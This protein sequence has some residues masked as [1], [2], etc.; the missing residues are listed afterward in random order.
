MA[1]PSLR[2]K[3]APTRKAL[4]KPV[5]TREISCNTLIFFRSGLARDSL[6]RCSPSATA[7]QRTRSF[8]I[9]GPASGGR[10]RPR[11]AGDAESLPILTTAGHAV[12][13]VR[14]RP[15][16]ASTALT[17]PTPTRRRYKGHRE[18]Y[19]LATIE[20]NT[21]GIV[22]EDDLPGSEALAAWLDYLQGGS[23]CELRGVFRRNHQGV[24]TLAQSSTALTVRDL[25]TMQ[26]SHHKA[27]CT[28]LKTEDS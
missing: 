19:R 14:E 7:A 25:H 16:T 21:L 8:S 27:P 26:F 24:V 9:N 13:P 4:N 5:A 20:R 3:F 22:R 11:G 6:F 18:N 15:C 23:A 10:S 17:C 2:A 12:G 1:R 28:H